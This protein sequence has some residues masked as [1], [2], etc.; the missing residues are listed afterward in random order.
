MMYRVIVLC[1]LVLCSVSLPTR[2]ASAPVAPQVAPVVPV[3]SATPTKAATVPVVA[4]SNI[5]SNATAA[6]NVTKPLVKCPRLMQ[7][8]TA[9]GGISQTCTPHDNCMGACCELQL[10][11][12]N[13]TYNFTV[14]PCVTPSADVSINIT[15]IKG[16]YFKDH[17]T[18]SNAAIIPH[19]NL[20]LSGF[21]ETESSIEVVLEK[22]LDVT[23]FRLDFG[24]DYR[25]LEDE[26]LRSLFS[27]TF[28]PM[29]TLEYSKEICVIPTPPPKQTTVET[30]KAD[31][32]ML[33][34]VIPEE[35][36]HD[37]TAITLLATA[38]GLILI[39]LVALIY[40]LVTRRRSH[41]GFR[42]AYVSAE[43]NMH[44]TKGNDGF[45]PLDDSDID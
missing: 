33:W 5:T 20:S 44:L 26:P 27:H 42:K 10:L 18:S 34:G 35:Y 21:Y 4:A 43:E 36:V 13:I 17:F 15:T 7:G 39:L 1:A 32:N 28:V 23:H 45:E 30:K 11:A 24:V 2:Q 12:N 6:S 37:K 40:C 19:G 14:R 16:A 29:I 25:I 8:L 9:V 41:D 22:V 3:A 38:G 31:E